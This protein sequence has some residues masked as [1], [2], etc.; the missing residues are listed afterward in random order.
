MLDHG[1]FLFVES[2]VLFDRTS[3][4]LDIGKGGGQNQFGKEILDSL[5]ISR[6]LPCDKFNPRLRRVKSAPKH[7]VEVIRKEVSLFRMPNFL[8][9]RLLVATA[10]VLIETRISYIKMKTVVI[11]EEVDSSL[12]ILVPIL[13]VD[14]EIISKE[15]ENVISGVLAFS[16]L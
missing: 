10:K 13:V 4:I 14:S 15:N 2:E 8:R 16:H 12:Q 6:S 5:E 7:L 11:V 1:Y 9:I 3:L